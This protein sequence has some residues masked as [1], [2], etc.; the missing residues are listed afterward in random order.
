MT[1]AATSTAFI[2][3]A[4]SAVPLGVSATAS[5]MATT[6]TVMTSHALK[7]IVYFLFRGF[8]VFHDASFEVQCLARH[9]VIE[10]YLY[11]VIAYFEYT[12]DKSV[13]FLIL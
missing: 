7:E 8:S 2:V 11:L 6:A 13:T 1:S 9:W 10:V 12:T 3:V 4:A 5:A